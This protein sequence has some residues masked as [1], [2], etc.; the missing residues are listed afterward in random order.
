MDF[1]MDFEAVILQHLV[2]ITDFIGDCE[3]LKVFAIDREFQ[4]CSKH[5]LFQSRMV[6]MMMNR[7]NL[8]PKHIHHPIDETVLRNEAVRTKEM[9]RIAEEFVVCDL[10]RALNVSRFIKRRNIDVST[11]SFVLEPIRNSLKRRFDIDTNVAVRIRNVPSSTIEITVEFSFCSRSKNVRNDA[12]FV[13]RHAT[14]VHQVYEDDDIRSRSRSQS[15]ESDVSYELYDGQD[16]NFEHFYA[17]G[18]MNQVAVRRRPGY[19][20]RLHG[21]N[22]AYRYENF[23]SFIR[24]TSSLFI[25]FCVVSIVLYFTL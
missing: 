2:Q 22:D 17:H 15:F 20:D 19:N 12:V 16:G 7:L 9:K 8:L 18:T 11:C 6:C 4:N 13:V 5:S 1:V 24:V 23:V 25:V 21:F 10:C 14:F 3:I